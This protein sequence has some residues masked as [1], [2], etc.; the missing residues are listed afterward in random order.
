MKTFNF[1]MILFF[2]SSYAYSKE[3]T[4]LSW[5][6]TIRFEESI[7]YKSDSFYIPLYGQARIYFLKNCTYSGDEY[8]DYS[9]GIKNV[10]GERVY[11]KIRYFELENGIRYDYPAFSLDKEREIFEKAI[12]G[13]EMIK[14][15]DYQGDSF[16]TLK[17]PLIE[18]TKGTK[19]FSCQENYDK[20]RRIFLSEKELEE[21]KLSNKIMS[22]FD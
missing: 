5:Q 7:Q 12:F 17:L 6:E 2:F 15:Y 4:Q 11:P 1:L 21:S 22:F 9:Y 18:K 20:E 16:I 14:L 19:F 3:V 10:G 13:S 8:R